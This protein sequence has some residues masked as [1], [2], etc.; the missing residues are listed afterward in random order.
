MNLLERVCHT[1][2]EAAVT[3]KRSNAVPSELSRQAN[4]IT[5]DSDSSLISFCITI[6]ALAASREMALVRIGGSLPEKLIS[7]MIDTVS[8]VNI[9]D[10]STFMKLEVINLSKPTQKLFGYGA[11]NPI[12]QIGKFSAEMS[13][14]GRLITSEILVIHDH[15]RHTNILGKQSTELLGLV[16]FCNNINKQ[17]SEKED[18]IDTCSF[19]PIKEF[20]TELMEALVYAILRW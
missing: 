3:S 11:E 10:H 6:N 18:R 8:P 12:I 16:V 20:P 2:K 5:Q 19:N 1:S 17:Q 9:I 14:G 13:S 4:A 15:P 7:M